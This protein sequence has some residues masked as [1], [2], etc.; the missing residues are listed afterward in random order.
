LAAAAYSLKE[1]YIAKLQPA[2]NKMA[3]QQLSHGTT[4]ILFQNNTIPLLSKLISID[5][6]PFCWWRLRFH[7]MKSAPQPQPSIIERANTTIELRKQI[8][9]AIQFPARHHPS[10]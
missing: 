6:S 7:R 3:L 4:A 8:T 2:I 10:S 5:R 1:V 9:N